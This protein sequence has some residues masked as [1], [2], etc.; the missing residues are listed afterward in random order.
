M[1]SEAESFSLMENAERLSCALKGRRIPFMRA[2][3]AHGSH[4]PL[5]GV[6]MAAPFVTG[7]ATLVVGA[8]ECCWHSKNQYY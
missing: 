2:A 8:A 6:V 5:F 4:C 1:N 3:I 7:V